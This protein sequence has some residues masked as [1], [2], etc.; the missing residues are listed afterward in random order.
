MKAVLITSSILIVL[1]AAL[2][3]ILRGKIDPRVQYALWAIVALRLLV[4]VELASSSFSAMN[5]M[6]RVEGQTHLAQAIGQAS[7]PVPGVSY[8]EAY[9]QAVREYDRTLDRYVILDDWYVANFTPEEEAMLSARAH[10]L[11]KGPT[12]AQMAERYAQPVWLGG[13][14]LMAAWFLL[15]NLR[16]RRKLRCALPV[17]ADCPLPVY[18]TPELPSPCLCGVFR[19]AVYV[20]PEALADPDRLRHV[21]AHEL[22]HHRHRDHWWALVRCACL[23]LY[24]FDPLVWWAAALS[25]QDGELAC[26]A[27]AIR[28]LGEAERIPYG[29]TLVGMIAAGRTSLMQTATTMTGGKKRVKERVSLIARRPKTVAAAALAL[30][31]VLALAVGC[32]FTGAPEEPSAPALTADTLQE[33]LADIPEELQSDVVTGPSTQSSYSSA[34]ASYWM[35]RPW[36]DYSEGFGWLLTVYRW[37]QE[38][39]DANYSTVTGAFDCFAKD[40]D[41]FYY[42]TQRA[43]DVRWPATP[44]MMA[45]FVGA[46]QADIDNNIYM[47]AFEA[48]W[49]HAIQTVLDTEGMEPFNLEDWMADPDTLQDRLKIIPPWLNGEVTVLPMEQAVD[50]DF[51][52]SYWMDRDWTDLDNSGLGWLLSVERMSQAEFE[53]HIGRDHSGWECFARN[54][55]TY[56]A[57]V[58]ATDVRFYSLDDA[59]PFH[60][61]FDAIREYAVQTVLATEGVEPF[62]PEGSLHTESD[63]TPEQKIIRSVMDEIVY[64]SGTSMTLYR[65]DAPDQSSTYNVYT[66]PDNYW[67]LRQTSLATDFEWEEL[68]RQQAAQLMEQGSG[69]SLLIAPA[70]AASPAC[71]TL[72][73]GI[74]LM[75]VRTLDNEMVWYEAKSLHNGEPLGVPPFLWPGPYEGLRYWY[76]MVELNAL[77]VTSVPDRGQNHEDVVKEWI[78]GFEGAYAKCAPGGMY[79]CTYV[80]GINVKADQPEG[81][82][83]E[84]LEAFAQ[85]AGLSADNFTETWFGFSYRLIFVPENET[86]KYQLEAG[87]TEDYTGS[88][89]PEG[90][91]IC[92]RAA[93]MRLIDGNWV[94]EMT[95]TDW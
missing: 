92:Y 64:A 18:V 52:V 82:T 91:Q 40:S 72:Y 28:R 65:P 6:N 12:L 10:E 15:V 41:G 31:V 63:L 71:I 74:Q 61:A 90:A 69:V 75:A 84:Q 55:E 43:T 9:L 19:P 81:L 58:C 53:A 38:E 1:I 47:T 5:L 39:F 56:Y 34:L 54:G 45:E 36:T 88:D 7:I 26:D 87:N 51:L 70:G 86:A 48:M 3:P 17:E 24:W 59:E 4:P 78:E 11:Q 79:T 20:T 42:V 57:I 93:Y 73:E 50:A 85:Y 14:A 49:A 13:A 37:N 77:R 67:P 62:S 22:T 44:E 76:D 2:R 83:H 66:S 29:R 95:G 32:T 35:K 27:G 94:C 89:A 25:R 8:D 80:R 68:T 46:T 33:R 30:V 21:L 23:C 60:N 16:L